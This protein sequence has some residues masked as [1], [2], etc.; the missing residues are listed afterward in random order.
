M[1]QNLKTIFGC[2]Q[3]KFLTFLFLM[4]KYYIY[5]CKFQNKSPSFDESKTFVTTNKGLE[6]N[7]NRKITSFRFILGNGDLCYE[8]DT[9]SFS[10]Q[11]KT[12][13]NR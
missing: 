4:L 11:F 6:Y 9:I 2:D 10:V 7:K 5:L 3:D 12:N 8:I 13:L 1:F